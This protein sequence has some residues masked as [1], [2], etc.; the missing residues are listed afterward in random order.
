MTFNWPKLSHDQF[1]EQIIP[2]EQSLH[3]SDLFSDEGLA[4]LL[5]RYPRERMGVY[6]FPH[7][8]EGR[9]RAL[10]GHAQGV[11]GRTLLEA[12]R[13]G[14]IW[15][16]L[17]AA[18][19]CLPAYQGIADDL[20]DSIAKAYGKTTYRWD[21]GVLIS[22]PNIHVHYHL[23]ASPVCLVQIRGKK[24]LWIYPPTAPYLS[25]EQVEAM[26]M[27]EREEDLEFRNEFDRDAAVFDLEPGH[28]VTW[29]QFGPH[30]VQNA[31]VMNVSLSCEFQTTA[32]LLRSSAVYA[33]ANLRRTLGLKLPMPSRIGPTVAMRAM[34]SRGI[35]VI[36]KAPAKGPT[37]ITFRIDPSTGGVA[38]LP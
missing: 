22:S 13:E 29:P 6:R 7:H 21:V 10:H 35:R 3:T 34:L 2:A 17:R 36:R 4:D 14:Q 27:R 8:A 9:V 37:P 26:M 5:D 24:R 11:S 16:N 12:V 30:R 38:E 1:G 25:A 19:R 23:D 28:A 31:D 32:T 15:L 18:N 20:R 33:N